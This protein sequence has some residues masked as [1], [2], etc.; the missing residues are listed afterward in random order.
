[1]EPLKIPGGRGF[2]GMSVRC[3]GGEV[4]SKWVGLEKESGRGRSG[5]QEKRQWSW[6]EIKIIEKFILT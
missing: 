4:K 6:E 5:Q 3:W 2:G 1:M